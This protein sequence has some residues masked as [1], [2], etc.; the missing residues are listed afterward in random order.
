MTPL[1]IALVLAARSPRWRSW[2]A[3]MLAET[4]RRA[5]LAA[6]ARGL[7]DPGRARPG[8]AGA[9][10]R[11]RR[12]R[13]CSRASPASPRRFTPTGLRREG[14]AASSCSPGNPPNLNVDKIL[15]MKLL[16]ARVGHRLDPARLLMLDVPGHR[17]LFVGV[18]V[19]VG[20]VVHLSR[21][22]PQPQDRGPPE[23]DLAQ[24]ARHPRPARDLGRSRSRFRAG[25][26][27][28]VHGGARRAVGRV[29]PHAARDPHRLDAV[30]TRCARW[31]SAPTCPSCARS[32][33]P[34]SRPTPSVC[35][36]PA[37]LRSQADEMRI[38]RRLAR[39]GAGAEGAGQDA[40]PARVLHL[41]VDLRRDPRARVHPD[42]N[43]SL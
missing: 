37:L 32:S 29:P 24:A 41:P 23:G 5:R 28:H 36:S 38:R 43:D 13:R 39:A 42:L 40:V 19:A 12:S 9:D 11:A 2:S 26:R 17:S 33:S 18:G 20:R 31:P 27:P 34:C 1:M 25:A 4:R 15:V 16:G 22:A 35:R 21:R 7:P 3:S 6:P 30:P 14:R 8:D 10:Q